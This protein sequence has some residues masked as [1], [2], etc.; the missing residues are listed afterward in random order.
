MDVSREFL[1]ASGL[2]KRGDV[3]GDFGVTMGSQSQFRG[4]Q[5]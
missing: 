2:L 5:R 3:S 4:S 1:E